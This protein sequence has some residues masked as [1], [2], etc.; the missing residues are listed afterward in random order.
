[1]KRILRLAWVSVLGLCVLVLTAAPAV[2]DIAQYQVT[3]NTSSLAGTTGYIDL[4]FN[5]G[6]ST[7][8]QASA[9]I[10]HFAGGSLAGSPQLIGAVSGSLA[11][12]VAIANS[13]GWNDYFEQI[14]FGNSTTFYL[15]VD[16]PALTAPDGIAQAGSIFG[17]SLFDNSISPLLTLDPSGFLFT[18]NVNLDGTTTPFGFSSAVSSTPVT[19]VPEPSLILLLFASFAGCAVIFFVFGRKGLLQRQ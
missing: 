10:S 13:G 15:K 5:P 1:M 4:Q 12:V 9:A 8:Q 18:L 19:A 3:I 6:D 14:T 2:A 17:L 7:S 16:G 11:S